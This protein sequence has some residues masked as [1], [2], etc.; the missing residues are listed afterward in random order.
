MREVRLTAGG[1]E[2]LHGAGVQSN[3]RLV[4]GRVKWRPTG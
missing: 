2:T 3:D 4:G 1:D